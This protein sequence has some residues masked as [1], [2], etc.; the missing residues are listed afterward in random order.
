M[1]A[2]TPGCH[3]NKR[4]S[5]RHCAVNAI[6]GE[7]PEFYL[8]GMFNSKF[9]NKTDNP[10]AY[11]DGG[12]FG[13][14][15]GAGMESVGGKDENNGGNVTFKINHSLI[16]EFYG[17]GINS[18]RPVTGNITVTIDNSKVIKYCGGPKVGDMSNIKAIITNATGTTFDEFYGGGNGG[19]NLLRDRQYDDY[20]LTAPSKA[21]HS[22]WD[23]NAKGKF[24][25][26]I[27]F[28]YDENTPSK[29]YLA[30]Y[31]FELLPQPKGDAKVV[32][33]SYYYWASFA[34]TTVA[35]VTNTITD[36]TFNGNFYGGGNLGAVDSDCS[37]A[38]PH[39]SRK[40]YV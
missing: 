28:T 27:T 40:E 14:V 29:G 35:P 7:Y 19:T 24:N 10:H 37:R 8:S 38:A 34:K 21:D 23:D 22:L 11:L 26:F 32:A 5:T 12:K 20:N 33:R 4:I 17:G 18:Q 2:F 36:C 15:A 16:D 1:K 39:Q 25:G 3:G 6:G 9:Y 31:E 30:E 13:I